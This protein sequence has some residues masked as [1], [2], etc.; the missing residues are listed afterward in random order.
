M[1]YLEGQEGPQTSIREGWDILG[2][3]FRCVLH[4]GCGIEEWRGTYLNSGS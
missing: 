4:F 1:S 3:E 2:T